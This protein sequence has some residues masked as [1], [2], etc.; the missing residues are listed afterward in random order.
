MRIYNLNRFVPMRT[1]L[2]VSSWEFSIEPNYGSHLRMEKSMWNFSK[3]QIWFQSHAPFNA[4]GWGPSLGINDC[5]GVLFCARFGWIAS[6]PHFSF[7]HD[8]FRD[9]NPHLRAGPYISSMGPLCP[10]SFSILGS[11]WLLP[12]SRQQKTI[13]LL[14]PTVYVGVTVGA[15][16]WFRLFWPIF[17][18]LKGL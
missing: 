10:C 12:S 5:Q 11:R 6:A 1:V 9:P 14:E 2:T 8:C 15:K 17:N 13:N 3:Y 16:Y 4:I 18:P 7:S